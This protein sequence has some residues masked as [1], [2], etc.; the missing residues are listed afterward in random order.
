[1]SFLF[2][3]MKRPDPVLP[4]STLD[5]ALEKAAEDAQLTLYF[6]NLV[7]VSAVIPNVDGLFDKSDGY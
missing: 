3:P 6:V 2:T 4:D 1:M 5:E 7:V